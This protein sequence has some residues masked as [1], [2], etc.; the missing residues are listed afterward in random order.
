VIDLSMFHTFSLLQTRAGVCDK[1]PT[2]YVNLKG[3]V[4]RLPVVST[5]NY[6][7]TG[8]RGTQSA[9]ATF[10]GCFYIDGLNGGSSA[11]LY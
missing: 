6:L 10:G 11:A 7:D 1:V 9:T 8:I 2:A 5:C 3:Y 4:E